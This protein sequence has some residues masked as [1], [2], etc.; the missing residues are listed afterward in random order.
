MEYF[1]ARTLYEELKAA[2]GIEWEK[3]YIN[4]KMLKDT[5]KN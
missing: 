2:D 5:N 3:K 4:K 1:V